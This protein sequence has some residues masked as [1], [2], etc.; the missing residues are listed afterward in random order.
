M[1]TQEEPNVLKE[2]TETA[3]RKLHELNEEEL[4]QVKGGFSKND[5]GTYDIYEGDSFTS[6]FDSFTARET[7]LNASLDTCIICDYFTTDLDG[8]LIDYGTSYMQVRQL[9]QTLS[10]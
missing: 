4:K 1:K 6:R 8:N 3:N 10:R 5:D 7:R 9:L 2:K